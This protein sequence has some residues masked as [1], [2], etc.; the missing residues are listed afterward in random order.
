MNIIVEALIVGGVVGVFGFILSTCLMFINKDFSL[1]KYN[2]WMW[3][4]FSYFITGFL[5]H[6]LA[7]LTGVNKWYCKNGNACKIKK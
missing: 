3:V 1:K 6:L 4:L 7:E 5:L 2:F